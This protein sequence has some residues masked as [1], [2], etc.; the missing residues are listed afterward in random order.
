MN[1]G[2]IARPNEESFKN[3]AQK[4]LD[5]LE[6]CINIGHDT[7]EFFNDIEKVKGWISQYNVKVGS[8]GRWGSDRIDKKGNIIEEELQISYKLIDA[9]SQLECKNFVC[10]CN[11]VEEISYYENCTAA[12]N[13]FS[14]LIEYGNKKGVK[15]SVYNCRWNNFVNNPMAW[16]IIHGHLK[17]LGIKFD[18]SHSYYDN[19]NYLKEMRDWGERFYHVHIKGALIID[20]E[21]FDDPPAG[22]DQIDWGSFM[23]ILY[24]KGYKDGLSIEPHSETWRGELADKGINFTIDYMKKLLFR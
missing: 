12:I 20:G 4:N 19:G 1:L 16:T 10:G 13:Y 6:F 14:K 24:A 22:I 15:I 8:I 17:D 3:A 18:P 5:F 7:D 21:R 23:S 2:I 9:A 11:Y